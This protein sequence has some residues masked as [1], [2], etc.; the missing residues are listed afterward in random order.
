MNKLLRVDT[1]TQDQ[2]N[3]FVLDLSC[4]LEGE[5]FQQ[6]SVYNSYITELTLYNDADET[7]ET[8]YNKELI[9]DEWVYNIYE[10]Q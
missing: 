6:E 10:A 8:L 1:L 4:E 2:F 7:V 5:V 3:E 9:N